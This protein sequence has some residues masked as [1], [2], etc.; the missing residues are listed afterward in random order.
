MSEEIQSIREEILQDAMEELSELR[1]RALSLPEQCQIDSVIEVIDYYEP[2]LA[3]YTDLGEMI[4][5]CGRAI[6]DITHELAAEQYGWDSPEAEAIFDEEDKKLT[7]LLRWIDRQRA[8][9][10]PAAA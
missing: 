9:S 3:G 7:Q 6:A 1:Q 5:W 8:A 2:I 4:E 10:R